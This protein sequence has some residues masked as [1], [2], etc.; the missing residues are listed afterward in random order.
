MVTL[1]ARNT[2]FTNIQHR[3]VLARIFR[4]A[5]C[6]KL[7]RQVRQIVRTSLGFGNQALGLNPVFLGPF[8]V[9]RG[10]LHRIKRVAQGAQRNNTQN[11]RYANCPA[12]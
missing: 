2:A 7:T 1:G 8:Q 3:I 4:I 5:R 6:H 11:Q 10:A 12:D 9:G